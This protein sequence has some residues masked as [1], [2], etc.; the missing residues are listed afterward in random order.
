MSILDTVLQR[1]IVRNNNGQNQRRSTMN[2]NYEWQ[3][4]QTNQ[5]LQ[6][7]RQEAHQ[8]RLSKQQDANSHPQVRRGAS[9]ACPCAWLRPF[10]VWAARSTKSRFAGANCRLCA[11]GHLQFV[12]DIRGQGCK[13]LIPPAV[14][15]TA[16]QAR[17]AVVLP[18]ASA[19][20]NATVPASRSS[21]FSGQQNGVISGYYNT[22]CASGIKPHR[23]LLRQASLRPGAPALRGA[24]TGRRPR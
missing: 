13:G 15:A 2:S 9:F 11:V 23:W 1:A 16:A 4:Q 22:F 17:R 3:Q 14:N 18:A 10:L 5:R 24:L 20:P 21:R 12:V 6:K 7:R 19:S 8:H